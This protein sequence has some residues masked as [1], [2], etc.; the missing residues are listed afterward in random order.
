MGTVRLT[1]D[2]PGLSMTLITDKKPQLGHPSHGQKL[3]DTRR[4]SSSPSVLP[5]SEQIL[6]QE[7]PITGSRYFKLSH[8]ASTKKISLKETGQGGEASHTC[9]ST[10]ICRNYNTK[11]CDY[12]KCCRHHICFRCGTKLPCSNC[13]Q[14]EPGSHS[15]ATSIRQFTI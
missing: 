1:A 6:M 13:L 11:S 5:E 2:I 3:Q 15:M 7:L 9:K 8:D 12:T 4:L 10:E 14:Q